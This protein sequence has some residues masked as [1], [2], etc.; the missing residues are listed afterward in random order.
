LKKLSFQ[1]NSFMLQ[2]MGSE[3]KVK[4]TVMRFFRGRGFGFI[5][6]DGGGKEV[7]VHWE[8]LV[9]DDHWPFLEKGTQVEFTQVDEDGKPAAKEVT[10]EDGDKIPIFTKPYEDREVNKKQTYTGSVKFF[11]GRKGFGFIE[12]DEEVTWKKTSSGEGLFFSRDGILVSKAGK[13]MILRVKGSLRVSF[14]V[15]KDKKGLGACDVQNE[16]ETPLECVPR[17]ANQTGKKRKRGGGGKK[18]PAKKAKTKEELMEEREVDEDENTYIG[19]VQVY[20]PDKEFGFI[21]ITDEITFKDVTVKEKIYVMKEDIVCYSDEVGLTVDSE[22]MFKIYKDSKG[23]GA[24]EVMNV[25]GSPIEYS[26]E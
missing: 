7:Y 15:Y 16:D 11:D 1:G 2:T 5:K 19:T 22:V 25:D 10:L 21:K 18:K 12:P 20:K 13:G 4:G 6:P 24:C 17:P 9:T 14:K 3:S 8:D 26:K 23:L